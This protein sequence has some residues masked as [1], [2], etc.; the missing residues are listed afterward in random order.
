[1]NC[2]GVED[3]CEVVICI[4]VVFDKFN[5]N[6]LFLDFEVLLILGDYV[7]IEFGIGCVYIVLVYGVDDFNVGK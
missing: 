4:G 3:F 1:M 6:Y 2:Y 5:V 7:M